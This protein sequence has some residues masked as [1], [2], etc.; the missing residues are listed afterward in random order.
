MMAS[1]DEIIV[2]C[3]QPAPAL[4]V[5]RAEAAADV[6]ESSD[7]DDIEV[8]A[9]DRPGTQD[10]AEEAATCSMDCCGAAVLVER[11]QEA[12]TK[13]SQGLHLIMATMEHEPAVYTCLLHANS[14]ILLRLLLCYYILLLRVLSPVPFL[15]QQHLEVHIAHT[16]AWA[17]NL[18]GRRWW[19]YVPHLCALP[20]ATRSV[21][22]TST[23]LSLVHLSHNLRTPS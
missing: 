6:I 2:V 23:H 15:R 14:A 1:D 5:H 11:V 21:L 16:S 7:D 22:G 9:R 12:T 13:A 17:F 4:P 10:E 3:E 19:I 8:V 20:V 18:Q